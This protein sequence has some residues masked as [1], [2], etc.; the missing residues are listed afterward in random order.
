MAAEGKKDFPE[1]KDGYPESYI[2]EKNLDKKDHIDIN[3]DIVFPLAYDSHYAFRGPA[4]TSKH[5]GREIYNVY[6]RYETIKPILVQSSKSK[7]A[8]LSWHERGADLATWE[9]KASFPEKLKI[10]A[11]FGSKHYFNRIQKHWFPYHWEAHH[12][13]P[14]SIFDE[15]TKD[16]KGQSYF[17]F[18]DKAVVERSHYDINNGH[19]VMAMPSSRY[20]EPVHMLLRHTSSHAKWTRKVA[21]TVQQQLSSSL[22]Q[23]RSK[24]QEGKPHEFNVGNVLGAL[25]DIEEELWSD[26]ALYSQREITRV[27]KEVA[28]GGVSLNKKARS[29][30]YKQLRLS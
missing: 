25:Y 7:S 11:Y 15:T 5:Q 6:T 12:L 19:N 29:L 9:D 21:S 8:R 30:L 10:D 14:L 17:T 23:A 24:E 18:E 28:Q 26:L 16:S 22:K 2:K 3:E 4:Y 13:I 20:W 1:L 27:L